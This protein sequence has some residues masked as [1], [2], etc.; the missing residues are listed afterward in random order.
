MN[1]F[2]LSIDEFLGHDDTTP[3]SSLADG[4]FPVLTNWYVKNKAIRRRDGISRVTRDVNGRFS[5]DGGVTP[6]QLTGLFR[7]KHRDG[8][9]TVIAG[10]PTGFARLDGGVGG[11]MTAIP[12]A[13]SVIASDTH[14][15]SMRQY[16]NRVFAARRGAG[17]Y[18]VSPTQAVAAGIPAHST[19]PTL[20]D[21]VAGLL[22]A[23][24]YIGVVVG[25]N[26]ETL[27][28]SNPTPVSNTLTIGASRRIDWGTIPAPLPV[29]TDPQV[30]VKELYRTLPN[31]DGEYFFVAEI[32]NSDIYYLADN[33]TVDEL[34][35]PVSFENGMPMAN[36]ELVA[37]F[38]DHMFVSDGQKV[39]FSGFQ[40]PQG[41]LDTDVIPVKPD[42]GH[43]ISAL[44]ETAGR[45]IVGQTNRIDYVTGSGR[46]SF[47]VDELNPS[48]GISS[49][50]SLKQLPDGRLIWF[51][52]GRFFTANGNFVSEVSSHHIKGILD[53]ILAADYEYV[54]AVVFPAKDWYVVTLGA[55]TGSPPQWLIYDYKEERWAVMSGGVVGPG[56]YAVDTAIPHFLADYFDANGTHQVWFTAKSTG[57]NDHGHIY[58]MFDPDQWGD[59]RTDSNGIFPEDDDVYIPCRLQTRNIGKDGYKYIVTHVMV[60]TPLNA[61]SVQVKLIGN[62]SEVIYSDYFVLYDEHGVSWKVFRCAP[63]QLPDGAAGDVRVEILHA[64]ESAMEIHG[65][66]FSGVQFQRRS[67][68]RSKAAS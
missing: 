37:V 48:I 28:R 11:V 1:Q 5:L 44:L 8:T 19:A 68:T 9:I 38:R 53:T 10:H 14:F 58:R 52:A 64:K 42:F 24:A 27:D 66:K 16:K 7:F 65:I 2:E 63:L 20:A 47:R 23:G 31:R 26:S 32:P 49:N 17:L 50:A 59:P 25:K 22:T 41:F 43:R 57:G 35:D 34:G 33:V 56:G 60:E 36:I 67:R 18:V 55:R 12:L 21:N 15:W 45:L 13:N 51:W 61:G 46:N 29:F 39:A 3:A 54:S 62:N 40:R 6:T 4:A 30:G